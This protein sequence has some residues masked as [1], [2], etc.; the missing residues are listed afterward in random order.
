MH[1]LLASFLAFG[2]PHT[3]RYADWKALWPS[4]SDFQ[5]SMPLLWFPVLREPLN[6]SGYSDNTMDNA[7]SR[8]PFFPLPP[9]IAGRWSHNSMDQSLWER[10]NSSMLCRQ[11]AKLQKDWSIV[12]KVFPDQTLPE[13][14][15]Y[16]MVVNTRSF[17][18]EIPGEEPAKERDDRIALCPFMD[19]FNHGD[20][21]V[22]SIL[23]VQE[24]HVC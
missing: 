4:F 22:G 21:G 10:D 23:P 19:Y 9:S 7:P 13:Y 11:E 20:Q 8:K 15:Y 5:K 2:G 17:Y 16:W 24:G 12:S 1:G 18:F 14:T 3:H 6:E